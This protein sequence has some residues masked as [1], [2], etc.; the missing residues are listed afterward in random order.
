[1]AHGGGDAGYLAQLPD[2]GCIPF[3]TREAPVFAGQFQTSEAAPNL[4]S[5]QMTRLDHELIVLRDYLEAECTIATNGGRVVSMD[6]ESNGRY[7]FA[8]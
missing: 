3:S 2:T 5:L 4:M 1:M 8:Q 7:V 6:V